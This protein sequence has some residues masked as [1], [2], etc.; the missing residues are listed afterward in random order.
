MQVSIKSFNVNMEVKSSGIEFEVRTPDREFV[1]DCHLTMTGL[2][3][4]AGKTDK[5]NGEKISWNDFI[6]LMNDQETL[7]YAIGQARRNQ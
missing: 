2:V 7:K 1:G 5:K 6:A 4:C 3:W